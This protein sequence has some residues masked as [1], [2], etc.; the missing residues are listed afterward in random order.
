MLDTLICLG[1]R[2]PAAAAALKESEL[3]VTT[4]TGSFETPPTIAVTSTF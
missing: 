4:I 1:G 3:G 2:L